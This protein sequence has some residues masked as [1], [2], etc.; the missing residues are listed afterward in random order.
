MSLAALQVMVVEDHGFQRRHGAAAAGRTGHRRRCRRRADGAAALRSCEQRPARRPTWSWSTST[1]PAWTASSSSATSRSAA[2]RARV[3]L[4]SALDPALLNTV[5]TMARAYGLRV[6]GS[7]EKPLTARQARKRC[8]TRY[9]ERAARRR[10]RRSRSR[11]IDRPICAR[12]SPA[13]RSCRG[14]SR[15]SE[16]GNGKIGR[17]RSAGALATRRWPRG[18]PACISC[19]LIEREGLAVALTDHDARAGL[20]LETPLG[21]TTACA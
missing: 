18:A 2:W 10:R 14:S 13:A 4:V 12:R 5:Q 17:R 6:L 20:P 21:R 8:S 3:A 16:F 11:S 9:E 7:I 15:R 1:C 19:A